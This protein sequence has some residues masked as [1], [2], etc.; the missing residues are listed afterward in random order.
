MFLD[1]IGEMPPD[2]QA[3]LLRVIESRTFKRVGSVR[4]LPMDA[5]IVAATNRD[6][7]QEVA[8]GRFRFDLFQRLS[9]FPIRLPPLRE[10]GEDILILAGQFLA[11]VC[12][13][14]GAP[15][16]RLS[17]EAEA[18]LVSYDFPGNVRELKNVIERAV[19]LT[20]TGI[21]E[22]RHLPE[23]M[24]G[25]NI[26]GSAS[27]IRATAGASL[28]VEIAGAV[29]VG[30]VPGIDTL[31]GIQEKLILAVLEKAGGNRS[32]AARMLGISRFALLRRLEKIVSRRQTGD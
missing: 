4:E 5:R 6:L 28:P 7:N 23:R 17:R 31:E 27:T 16:A 12:M 26:G 15:E 25:M 14:M 13:A 30:F 11:Q 32:E 2:L 18:F 29:N 19:I 20:D 24:L 21:I 8:A 9:V 22:P 1:E 10:R 3:R